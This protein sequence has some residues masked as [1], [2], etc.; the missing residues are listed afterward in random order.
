MRKHISTLVAALLLTALLTG[1]GSAAPAVS[2]A[3]AG[4]SGGSERP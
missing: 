2:S 3:P 4:D 1:C